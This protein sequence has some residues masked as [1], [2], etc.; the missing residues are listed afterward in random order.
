MQRMNA[1]LNLLSNKYRKHSIWNSSYAVALFVVMSPGEFPFLEVR[2][3]LITYR[4]INHV[5]C[6][7]ISLIRV[8][9]N[10]VRAINMI[11]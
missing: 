10:F 4:A 8:I 1:G 3:I 7:I 6:A 11:D 9:T 5:V 2:A